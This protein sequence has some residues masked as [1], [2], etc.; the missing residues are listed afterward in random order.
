MATV[1]I[2]ELKQETSKILRRVREQR[3]IIDITYH[4]KVV[5]RLIPV[6]PP[7]PPDEK[8]VAVFTSLEALSAEISAQWPEGVS[9]PFTSKSVKSPKSS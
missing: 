6:T 4:G 1:G 3:E 7:T 2:S 8:I 5:A 9:T